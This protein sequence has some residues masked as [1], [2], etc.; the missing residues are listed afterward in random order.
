MIYNTPVGADLRVCPPHAHKND[1]NPVGAD[2][3][4]Y[5]HVANRTVPKRNTTGRHIG[6]PLQH[7]YQ[8]G[9]KHD[10]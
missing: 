6:L 5:P 1:T 9:T 4:V 10:T 2:L 7:A 8:N 3:R